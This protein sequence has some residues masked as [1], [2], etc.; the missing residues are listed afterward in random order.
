MPR[1]GIGGSSNGIGGTLLGSRA[2]GDPAVGQ[3]SVNGTSATYVSAPVAISQ[4]LG[5]VMQGRLSLIM[6]DTLLIAMI[7]FYLW[8]HSVQKGG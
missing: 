5:D 6:L 8:T 3:G 4:G 7:G 1:F 2:G